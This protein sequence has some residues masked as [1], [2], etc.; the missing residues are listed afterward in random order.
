[1]IHVRRRIEREQAEHCRERTDGE[2]GEDEE[3][4]VE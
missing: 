2:N 1:L 4:L 3:R